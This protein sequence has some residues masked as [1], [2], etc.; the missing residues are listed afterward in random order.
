MYKKIIVLFTVC[1]VFTS[2]GTKKGP[3][4]IEDA[5]LSKIVNSHYSTAPNFDT[6]TSR[7]RLNYTDAE[8]SQA[9]TVS[10]RMKK[11]STIWISA[12]VLGIP[13]AKALI[14][15]D[16]VSYY[17]KISKTYFDGDYSL[18]SQWLGTPLDFDK[19]QNLLL[20]N[21]IYDLRED[22]YQLAE[23]SRGYQLEP[24]AGYE[25]VKKM[26]L[27][28]PQNFRATAQQL[29]QEKE[30]RSVTVTYPKYQ[31]VSGRTIPEE[32]KIL[33]NEGGEG[34]QIEISFRSL[35]FN[36]PVSF[37]FEIPSGYEEIEID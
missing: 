28:D 14:T 17:E 24:A 4:E 26:F 2:C 22:R 34:T 15:R 19:L 29:S 30:N 37:P 21:T 9:V 10:Y 16:R 5:A 12:Q 7:M 36:E 18:L 27:L 8:R 13:L 25:A 20:G 33:A 23:S 31:K 6:M 35:S 1:V 32:I 3:A 11:D